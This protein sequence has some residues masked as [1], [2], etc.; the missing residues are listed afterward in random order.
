LSDVLVDVRVE[1]DVVDELVELRLRG[2]LALQD[3]VGDL[4]MGAALGE[5]L[6]GV[7]AVSEDPLVAVDVRDGAA[8]RCGV[9]VRGVVGHHPEVALVHLD[10]AEIHGSD[11]VPSRISIS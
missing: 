10:L 11:H 9:G 2:E 8:G 7:A 3:Q 6:D 4:E 1:R 5:L